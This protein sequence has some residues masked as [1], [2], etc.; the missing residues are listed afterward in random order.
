MESSTDRKERTDMS[1]PRY[2]NESKAYRRARDRLLKDEQALI[3]KTKAV[4]KKRRQLPLGGRLKEDYVFQWAVD[5]KVGK[6]V[7][8]SR[9]F[10]DKKT[11]L[12]YSFMFGPNWDNPCL[13]CTSL[14]DGFDRTWYQVS[15]DAAFVAIAKAPAHRI[16]AWAKKRGWT[17]M[18]L[19]SGYDSTYQADYKCQ[20]ESNDDMQWPVMHCFRKRGGKI[21]HFWGTELSGNHVDTV[22][23]YW[24]LMDFTPEGRPEYDVPPQNFRSKFLEKHFPPGR[25]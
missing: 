16:N 15:R 18:A 22:W 14:V 17:Q 8:C 7:K 24:N 2:P 4:A 21:Y 10:G 6:P 23:P 20:D 11:L 9:L 12:I 25:I 3:D 5:G 1:E 13:S 19:V